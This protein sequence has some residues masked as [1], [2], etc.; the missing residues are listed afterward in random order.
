MK[1]LILICL[2]FPAL[3]IAADIP[4]IVD[5]NEA[6]SQELCVARASADCLNTI[7][8][9]SPDINCSDNCKDDAVDKCQEMQE[10]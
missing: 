2:F 3:A 5:Q 10:E 9:T 8:P 7:C 6:D 1:Q 4:E